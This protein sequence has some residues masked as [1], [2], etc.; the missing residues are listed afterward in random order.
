MAKLPV[1]VHREY[2]D[3][4]EFKLKSIALKALRTRAADW[5]GICV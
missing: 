5:F 4:I 1:L 2:G 3:N